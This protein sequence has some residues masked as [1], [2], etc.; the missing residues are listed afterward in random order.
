MSN[1]QNVKIDG[2]IY[3]I[4]YEIK[5]INGTS[6]LGEG[7][8]EME[9]SS[10]GPIL[11]WSGAKNASNNYTAA[12]TVTLSTDVKSKLKNY[13]M[14]FFFFCVAGSSSVENPPYFIA[15]VPILLNKT[16]YGVAYGTSGPKQSV[17]FKAEASA[18]VTDS[19][20]TLT[21]RAA[22]NYPVLRKIYVV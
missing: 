15:T 5:T 8:L 7:N 19:T 12:S 9:G 10:G 11:I 22:G 13:S 14:L 3:S 18:T 1:I 17:V 2:N 6:L 20:A 16:S 4:N 21:T